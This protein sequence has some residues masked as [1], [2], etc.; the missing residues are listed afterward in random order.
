MQAANIINSNTQA[1]VDY[2]TT[3]NSSSKKLKWNGQWTNQNAST[4]AQLAKS[5][6]GCCAN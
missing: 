2:R 4:G 3:C 1:N 6:C 5:V